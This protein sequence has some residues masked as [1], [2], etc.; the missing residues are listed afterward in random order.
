[1]IALKYKQNTVNACS[2]QYNKKEVL[3]FNPDSK[4]SHCHGCNMLVLGQ[5]HALALANAG[6]DIVALIEGDPAEDDRFDSKNSR[7]F[8]T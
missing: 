2:C 8:T 7:N 1:M 6:A 4:V 5:G 3:W